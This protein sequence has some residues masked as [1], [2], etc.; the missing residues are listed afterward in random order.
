MSQTQLQ[1]SQETQHIVEAARIIAQEQHL[2]TTLMMNVHQLP[3]CEGPEWNT[4]PTPSAEEPM[5]RPPTSHHRHHRRGC[6]HRTPPFRRSRGNE[7]T[8][9][10]H[11]PEPLTLPVK[12]HPPKD[13]SLPRRRN[14]RPAARREQERRTGR[15]PDRPKCP[16]PRAGSK[17]IEAV[18]RTPDPAQAG[19]DHHRL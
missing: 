17:A 14:K 12:M 11:L 8:T 13:A 5:T 6:H 10:K 18:T 1:S 15:T 2:D 3:S 16:Q 7:R 9:L 4:N 19:A